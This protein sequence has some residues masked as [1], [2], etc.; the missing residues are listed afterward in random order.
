VPVAP[1]LSPRRD[2]ALEVALP[3]PHFARNGF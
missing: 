2:I 3:D 1:M